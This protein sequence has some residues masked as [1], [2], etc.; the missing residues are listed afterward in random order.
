MSIIHKPSDEASL[1]QELE[2]LRAAYTLLLRRLNGYQ[3]T[4][5][6]QA[7]EI[8]ELRQSKQHGGRSSST[9]IKPL[10][11]EVYSGEKTSEHRIT[12][13][14]PLLIRK[15]LVELE[16]EVLLTRKSA[17]E[18]LKSEVSNLRNDPRISAESVEVV[19]DSFL[20]KLGPSF[21]SSFDERR[22]AETAHNYVYEVIHASI[23]ALSDD[24]EQ[25]NVQI[26]EKIEAICKNSTPETVGVDPS[27]LQ[28]PLI[29]RAC[30]EFRKLN[31]VKSPLSKTRVLL[32]VVELAKS[33]LNS[34]HQRV[35]ERG[36]AVPRPPVHHPARQPRAAPGQPALPA[37]LLAQGAPH[38]QR[39]LHH[40]RL[41]LHT[42]LPRGSQGQLA[43]LRPT[44]QA[45]DSLISLHLVLV[46]IHFF[47]KFI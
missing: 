27:L 37:P 29:K 18:F 14:S 34:R 10:A 30:L 5:L 28:N 8:L 7:R 12:P 17:Y 26:H 3:R 39:G 23:F 35:S 44:A 40:L 45:E 32:N 36:S 42:R 4:V 33:C 31:A 46:F 38:V 1:M 19:I 2:A 21:S 25:R 20:A 16:Q 47:I 6:S 9:P 41:P 11:E 24:E 15:E 43:L 22:L 13:V